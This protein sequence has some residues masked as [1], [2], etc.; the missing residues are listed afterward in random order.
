VG[1][2]ASA[3]TNGQGHGSDV[4]RE[5]FIGRLYEQAR[6]LL[7][8]SPGRYLK[9]DA[10]ELPLFKLYD[11]RDYK[12]PKWF[13]QKDRDE[14]VVEAAKRARADFTNGSAAVGNATNGAGSGHD[15]DNAEY[16]EH[17]GAIHHR[18][19]TK[20]GA[21]SERLTSFTARIVRELEYDDGIEV[22]LEFE[23][24]AVVNGRKQTCTMPAAD[25]GSLGWVSEK[26][27]A[28]AIVRAGAGTKDHTRVAILSLSQGHAR[29]SRYAHTGW[30]KL[31]GEWVYLHGDG[32][33]GERGAVEGVKTKLPPHLSLF[34][35]PAPPSDPREAVRTSLTI[36]HLAPEKLTAPGLAAVY[37]AALGETDF[38][39]HIAGASGV[40]KSEFAA[41]LQRHYGRGFDRE[42]LPM[43]WGS[44]ANANEGV[45]FAAKDALMVIDDFVPLG[46]AADRQRQNREADRLLRAQGNRQGR[47]RMNADLSLREGRAPRRLFV[48]TGEEIPSGLSLAARLLILDV[49]KGDIPK[50]KLT[51]CQNTAAAGLYA[52]AMSAYLNWLALRLEPVRALAAERKPD[53]REAERQGGEHPRTPGIAAELFIGFACFLAFALD[54]GALTAAKAD[55]YARR[56]W[57]GLREAAGAQTAHQQSED[58]ARRFVELLG[59]ALTSGSAHVA[60][61]EGGRPENAGVWGWR[62]M[63]WDTGSRRVCG[64]DGS[65]ATTCAWSRRLPTRRRN[66]WRRTGAGSACGR[67]RFGSG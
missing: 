52:E 62:E 17:E 42:H 34:V 56:V 13:T 4:E 29:E 66:R 11:R 31:Q 6:K 39:L 15:D 45:G 8:Q 58:P 23:V 27:G 60:T 10:L 63:S 55:E 36:L 28:G 47:N 24:E 38:S 37:R 51:A 19:I 67:P 14:A 41:L 49:A 26:L 35:L 5:H 53:L 21:I 22:R 2:K 48:S 46:S 50:V 9:A 32:A 7:G 61:A 64:S 16:F 25:F 18:R 3:S 20:D 12:P 44:T 1:T 33:I 54:C 59:A 30:R 40:F 57:R 65:I 43:S